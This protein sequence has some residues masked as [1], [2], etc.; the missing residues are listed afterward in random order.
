M[1]IECSRRCYW[2]SAPEPVTELDRISEC[3]STEPS[4]TPANTHTHT[5]AGAIRALIPMWFLV[6]IL[7]ELDY[8]TFGYLPSHFCLSVSQSVC[9]LSVTFMH[10]TQP[11]ETFGDVFMPF[12]SLAIR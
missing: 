7:L 5:P 3:R 6:S 1:T 12:C 4:L 10:P 2:Q 11:V 8:V 9:R